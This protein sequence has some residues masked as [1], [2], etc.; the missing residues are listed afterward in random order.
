LSIAKDIAHYHHEK[1]DGSGYPEGLRG[2]AIPIAARLM[3]LADVFDALMCQR[4]YKS[5]CSFEETVTIIE[6]GRGSHFDP[7][8]VDAFLLRRE[9]FNDIARRFADGEPGRISRPSSTGAPQVLEASDAP[10]T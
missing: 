10:V 2:D 8:V 3:A 5:P 6:Q 4:V 7:D 9:A 1:W